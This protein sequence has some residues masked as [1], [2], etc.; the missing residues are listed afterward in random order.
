MY[1]FPPEE[2]TG[3]C[4]VW[5]EYDLKVLE[6]TSMMEARMWWERYSCLGWR[7]LRKSL[8]DQVE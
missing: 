4:P 5:L 6:V 1:R 3:N 8:C 7:S 2:R